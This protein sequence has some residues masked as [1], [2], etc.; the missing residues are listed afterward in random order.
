MKSIRQFAKFP[1]L[2][3]SAIM[4]AGCEGVDFKMQMPTQ[5][6]TAPQATGVTR[7]YVGTYTRRESKGIYAFDLDLKTGA[8]TERGLAAEA[9]NPSFLSL[10]PNGRT[11]YA[12]NEISRFNDQKTGA[13]SAFAIDP[14]T[15]ALTL[16]GQQSSGGAGPCHVSLDRGGRHVL[17]ANYGGGSVA[18][19]PVGESGALGKAT[20]FVQH[21][22]SSV[23]PRRQTAPHAHSINVAPDNRH[24]IAADL[25][26]DKLLVYALDADQGSLA[27]KSSVRLAP[28]A[29]PRH[30]AFHPTGRFAYVINELHCT[31]TAF[32]YNADSGELTERQTISTLDVS[33]QKGFST[34]EVQV[35]PS[36]RF[37]YGSN[38]GHDSIAVFAINP[39]SGTLRRVQVVSSGGTTPRN[40][41]VDPTGNWLI[42]ANQNSD[43]LVVY[44]IDPNTGALTTT[45]QEAVVS[46]PVCVKFLSR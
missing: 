45:G 2:A 31:V 44:R 10:H 14:D 13:V 39:K 5:Q 15:G 1:L 21:T 34:A 38:R 17:V 40:F 28:G 4:F 16:L 3:L 8:L 23:N 20:A 42:A 25:G 11:L 30:F 26:I 46:S 43:N 33:L 24:A 41:G 19:L 37:L 7:V 18:C 12:A 32:G 29:G 22:G 36:G 6:T 27:E 35:H 9:D